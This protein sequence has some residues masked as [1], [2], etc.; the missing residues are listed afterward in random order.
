MPQEIRESGHILIE[1]FCFH[2]DLYL[3]L[4]I[5]LSR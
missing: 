5:I 2:L 3:S 4:S 1:I